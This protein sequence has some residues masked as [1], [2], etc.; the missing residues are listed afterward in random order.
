MIIME[1]IL[2]AGCIIMII[3]YDYGVCLIDKFDKLDSLLDNQVQYC[4]L[5]PRQSILPEYF[6]PLFIFIISSK[7][8]PHTTWFQ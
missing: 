3:F 6:S 8:G 2:I 7:H 5:S 4:W 1:W